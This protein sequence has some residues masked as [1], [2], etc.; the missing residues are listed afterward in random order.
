MFRIIKQVEQYD[1]NG[2]KRDR[3]VFTIQQYVKGK[4]QD[5]ESG[6]K[7]YT[8]AQAFLEDLQNKRLNKVEA[9]A[10]EY[11]TDNVLLEDDLS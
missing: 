11:D 7:T 10:E 1:F 9:P 3:N 5:A 6:F 8:E 2:F 4:Y